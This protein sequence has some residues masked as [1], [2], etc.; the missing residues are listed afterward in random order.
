[1]R[2]LSNRSVTPSRFTRH[3]VACWHS[4][5]ASAEELNRRAV[6]LLAATCTRYTVSFRDSAAVKRNY[7]LGRLLSSAWACTC[8]NKSPD[9]CCTTE[10]LRIL[11]NEKSC[12]FHVTEVGC[13]RGDSSRHFKILQG[14]RYEFQLV[15]QGL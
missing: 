15:H 8:K 3:P 13:G 7:A 9:I 1:M 5:R 2:S 10:V 11:L 12:L 4:K 6:Q 14:T